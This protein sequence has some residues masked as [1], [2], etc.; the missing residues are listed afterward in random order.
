VQPKIGKFPG[1]KLAFTG[2]LIRPGLGESVNPEAGLGGGGTGPL[3]VTE[4][5]AGEGG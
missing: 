2:S 3:T 5:V 1:L 4:A